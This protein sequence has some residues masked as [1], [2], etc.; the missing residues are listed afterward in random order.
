MVD[1]DSLRKPDDRSISVRHLLRFLSL[2]VLANSPALFRISEIIFLSILVSFH[3][4]LSFFK[5][6]LDS[7]LLILGISFLPSSSSMLA[8]LIISYR[9]EHTG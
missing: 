7:S 8:T 5:V 3:L 4:D 9:V 1:F 6:V 2:S